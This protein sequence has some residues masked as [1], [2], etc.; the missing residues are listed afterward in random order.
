[1]LHGSALA[2]CALEKYDE[3]LIKIDAAIKTHLDKS[4]FNH[5][6][7]IPCSSMVS[8]QSHKAKILE[9]LGRTSETRAAKNIA[10]REATDYPTKYT[11]VRGFDRPYEAYEKRLS[12]VF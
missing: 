9:S 5:N 8:M 10:A 7:D 3:A 12:E 1:M 6:I 4:H 11:R 2:L